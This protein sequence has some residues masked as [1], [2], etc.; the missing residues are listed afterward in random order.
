MY[1]RHF[2]TIPVAITGAPEPL[3]VAATWTADR[4]TLTISVVNPT[5]ETQRLALRV[6]G[7]RLAP[8]GTAWVLTAPDDMAYNEPG[9]APAVRFAETRVTGVQETLEVAPASATI[10]RIAVR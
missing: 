3:D 7:A 8:S 6:E 1:R 2:G 4:K 5:F 9:Q 10:F